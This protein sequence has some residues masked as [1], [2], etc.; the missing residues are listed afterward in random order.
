MY[1][2]MQRRRGLLCREV[3]CGGDWSSHIFGS[4]RRQWN[5]GFCLASGK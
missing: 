4:Y 1:I 5:S 3:S 2:H